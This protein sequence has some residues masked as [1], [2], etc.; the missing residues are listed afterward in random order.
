[1]I[2]ADK[3]WS[4]FKYKKAKANDTNAVAADLKISLKLVFGK[5]GEEFFL[6]SKKNG[7]VI[8][9]LKHQDQIPVSVSGI[10]ELKN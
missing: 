5:I 2:V 8:A 10:T 3:F 4:Y 6:M 1:M 7:R 9:R